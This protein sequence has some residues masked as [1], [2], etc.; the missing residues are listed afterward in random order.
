MVQSLHIEYYVTGWIGHHAGYGQATP[1]IDPHA[2][3]VARMADG[4][5]GAA[6]ALH[7]ACY[8]PLLRIARLIVRENAD[9]EEVVSDTFAKAWRDSA[10]FDSARSSVAGWLTMMVRSRARDLVRARMRRANA[11][12]RAEA[13]AAF[14][15]T[16]VNRG[17]STEWDAAR[18]LETKELEATLARA[19]SALPARQ[20]EAI[21]LVFLESVSHTTAA[22]QLGVPLGT[23]KTRVRLGLRRMR[24]VLELSG[25]TRVV[26]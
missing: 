12:D 8:P 4:D 5:D 14:D 9:A 16:D 7:H 24:V 21:E 13:C 11:H 22:D 18:M 15:T 6:A 26:R 23:I 19:L 2:S 10:N 17:G 1:T 3:L 25:V 20:R